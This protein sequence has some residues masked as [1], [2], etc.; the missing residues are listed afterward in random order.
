M[1]LDDKCSLLFEKVDVG[2]LLIDAPVLESLA[3]IVPGEPEDL[4]FFWGIYNLKPWVLEVF[5]NP[6]VVGIDRNRPLLGNIPINSRGR[7]VVLLEVL[8]KRQSVNRRRSVAEL[9]PLC[10]EVFREHIE[11]RQQLG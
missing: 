5:R 7:R 8:V 3:L 2:G 11:P 1:A 6:L 9:I 4:G 10:L